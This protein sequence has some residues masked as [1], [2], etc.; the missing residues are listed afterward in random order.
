[1]PDLSVVHDRL[2]LAVA[3]PCPDGWE[4]VPTP[5][6]DRFKGNEKRSCGISYLFRGA[7]GRWWSRE[8]AVG[9]RGSRAVH[10]ALDLDPDAISDAGWES[11]AFCR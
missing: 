7:A 5:M 3:E 8:W 11:R 10:R 2:D 9:Y 4:V 6:E 1:M